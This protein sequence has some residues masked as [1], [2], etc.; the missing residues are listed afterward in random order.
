MLVTVPRVS[1]SCK[2][3]PG[4]S[5]SHLLQF[6]SEDV[7]ANRVLGSSLGF[8]IWGSRFGVQD[9]G[10]RVHGSGFMVQSSWFRV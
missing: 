3:F 9:S 2:H 4:G 5:D 10:F 1:R 6:I 7:V 8:G